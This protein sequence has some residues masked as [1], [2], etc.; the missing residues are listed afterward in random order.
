M[1]RMKRSFRFAAAGLALAM[2]TGCEST[3]GGGS[4]SSV[5]VYYGVGFY[6]PWYYGDY[7]HNHDIVVTPP[8]NRPDG[9]VRP[10]AHPEQP[11]ARP[12]SASSRP[13]T[14]S[15]QPAARPM[16]SIPSTPRPAFSGGGG[17][18]GGRR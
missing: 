7:N 4:S 16:P 14:L 1:S 11:I 5:G 8:A 3:N 2:V 13:S 15:S 10:G 9:G 12:P 6:D 17:G 18:G